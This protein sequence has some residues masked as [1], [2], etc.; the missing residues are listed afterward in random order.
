[1]SDLAHKLG[2]VARYLHT[3]DLVSRPGAAPLWNRAAIG[4]RLTEIFGADASAALTVAL[5]L[6]VDAQQNRETAVWITPIHS[7]FFPPDAAEGGVDLGALAIVRVPST[8]L[9]RAADKLA[10]SGAFGLIVIDSTA[11]REGEHPGIPRPAQSRLLGLAQKYDTA[12]VFLTHRA[13]SSTLTGSLVSLRGE[14][15]RTRVGDNLHE[16]EVRVL[17]DKRRAPGWT[18]KEQ[19]YGPAGLR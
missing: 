9:Y 7:T 11:P 13:A 10:R 3:G 2:D 6:V 19:C 12:I 17:K 16:V 14:A 4:G 18:H 5:G 8:A 15:R 1:M